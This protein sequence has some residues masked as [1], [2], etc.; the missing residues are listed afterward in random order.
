MSKATDY[1]TDKFYFSNVCLNSVEYNIYI[2]IYIYNI[3]QQKIKR[4]DAW[5]QVSKRFFL[6]K[7]LSKHFNEMIFQ[8]HINKSVGSRLTAT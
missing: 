4:T 5:F 3:P 2:Y 7:P 8:F 1:F 6:S